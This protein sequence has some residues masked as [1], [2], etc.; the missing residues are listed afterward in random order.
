VHKLRIACIVV[1]VLLIANSGFAQAFKVYPGATKLA[2]ESEEA[3]KLLAG[4]GEGSVYTTADSYDKVVAFYKGFAK[5]YTMPGMPKT[6]KLPSGQEMV[7]T[8]FIFDGATKLGTSKCWAKVQRPYIGSVK[9]NGPTPEYGDIR[10]V[11]AI[12]VSQKK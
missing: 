4:S 3:S 12:V 1:S 8:F 10:D 6:T 7:S 9:M 5:E 2:K 11:T